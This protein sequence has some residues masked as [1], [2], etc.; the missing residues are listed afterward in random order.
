MNNIKIFHRTIFTSSIIILFISHP[1]LAIDFAQSPPGTIQ[2]YVAPNVIISIDDSGSMNFRLDKESANGA[3][4][5]TSPNS[6]GTW[7][8]TSRRINVLKHALKNIFNDTELLPDHKIRIGWQ[9]MWNNGA[10]PGVETKIKTAN[11]DSRGRNCQTSKTGASS[12]D[13]DTLGI[14]SIKPLDQAHRANFLNF[15]DSLTANQGTPSHWMMAQAD[16]YLRRHYKN[17]N[18]PWA[19]TPGDNKN[20]EYLGC[21]KNYHI[22]F[23]DGRWNSYSNAYSPG[24][25][26]DGETSK[27]VFPDGTP[28]ESSDQTKIYR[29]NHSDTLADWAFKSW[30]QNLQP[31]LYSKTDPSKQVPISTE[32][33]KAPESEKIGT[34][35]IQKYWNPKYNPANWPHMVTY[36]IGFSEMAYTWP[37][38]SHITAPTEK[39]PFGYDGSFPSLVSGTQSWPSMDSENKRSLD[40]WHAAINGRGKFFAVRKG[41]DL[42]KAFRSIVQ[43]ISISSE[44]STGSAAASGS[45][46]LNSD[47]GLYTSQYDPKKSWAGWITAQNLPSDFP[48]RSHSSDWNGKTT[49]SLLDSKSANEINERL[50]LTSNSESNTGIGFRWNNLSPT[51]KSF[52]NQDASGSTD[53]RGEA[54]LSYVRGILNPESSTPVGLTAFR[55]R[56]S[57][58]GDIVNSNIWYTGY[59]SS[60]YSYKGYQLFAKQ[61]R[62]RIPML[63]VGGNDGMLHG[64]SAI[65]GEERIAYIPKAVYKNLPIYTD[66]AFDEKHQY[67]VDGSPFT[68]DVD[69]ANTPDGNHEPDWRTL[70][71]GSLGAGGKG[72]FILDVTKP[73]PK[74]NTS[75]TGL[76]SN[77]SENQASNLVLMDK[78]MHA[79]EEIPDCSKLTHQEQVDCLSN[80]DIGH[81]FSPPV[82]DEINQLQSAQIT[83]LNNGRWATVM[84]NGYNSKNQRPVLL[85][86]YLDGDRSLH[87]IVAT[88]KTPTGSDKNT[89]HNGL[90]AP[91]LID[92]NGDG[93]A[94]I[95]YA[96]DLKGN[97]W[98]FDLT[99]S[100]SSEWNVAFDGKPLYT[101]YGSNNIST[102]LKNRDIP[103]PIF[104]APLAKP[105]TRID[106]NGQS[107]GGMMVAFG[108]GRNLTWH[109]ASD[110]NVQTFYGILDSTRYRKREN[111]NKLL[112]VH[113]GKDCGSN[114]I[115]CQ[116]V[117]APT[118]VAKNDSLARQSISSASHTHSQSDG[119]E[120]WTIE[121]SET[122]NW[123]KHKGWYLDLPQTS[124]RVLSNPFFYENSNIIAIESIVPAKGSTPDSSQ[125]Y[126]SC[127]STSVDEERK[128][129]TLIN[130]MDGKRPSVPLMD[131]NNDGYY[132]EL[133]LYVSRASLGKGPNVLIKKRDNNQLRGEGILV[134]ARMPE[135]SLRPSWRQ[136]K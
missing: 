91:R 127:E 22:L 134:L 38:A 43:Q 72:F 86:Q 85:I 129:F 67:Y 74:P 65:D 106:Q 40:L 121:A 49:A 39:V 125:H 78:T 3:Q 96:G 82:V 47:V 32:Y 69:I 19:T 26:I 36:T 4:N 44:P 75:N 45:S 124:E 48:E 5:N 11:C 29:D 111:N 58:Q 131:L 53:N 76:E 6:D 128:Y 2:P 23:T 61:N 133:D 99:S 33:R 123:S 17:P 42:E 51:Q 107:V 115:S 35:S 20:Q 97:L 64:F 101:A 114:S 130:I 41:E 108:T 116:P 28:F 37:G 87:R 24:G 81:I 93:A 10:A 1:V 98:K 56:F 62:D 31:D 94:D 112:E 27:T 88:K 52:L 12:I 79:Q 34:K 100:N 25:N 9:A 113:P 102:D 89:T 59:P 13:S 117:P 50:I 126:E 63:Y 83:K 70:L 21:R 60:R 46:T 84:G 90:S 120:F 119:R 71:V 54:R 15:I 68:G 95:A 14:N 118:P 110:T 30:S 135:T 8:D 73:G 132:N 122:I 104:T 103:Q 92:I 109:D 66:P 16:R 57:R 55:E 136:L 77:F 18:S 7:P 105:N 80:E